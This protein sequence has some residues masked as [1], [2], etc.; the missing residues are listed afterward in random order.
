MG[1]GE[2]GADL[3]A[4]PAV[5]EI[6]RS[7]RIELVTSS[8]E[9]SPRTSRPL[10]FP[11]GATTDLPRAV[12]KSLLWGPSA[13]VG[14]PYNVA[15]LSLGYSSAHTSERQDSAALTY[16]RARQ[17]RSGSRPIHFLGCGPRLPR[18][19]ADLGR[20]VTA[21]KTPLRPLSLGTPETVPVSIALLTR[22]S[23]ESVASTW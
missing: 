11:S 23:S 21:L 5:F 20:P 14:T 12:G 1:I 17:E 3:T 10:R 19:A 15:G 22:F 13:S 2:R 7:S 9:R 18:S 6:P 16:L 4:A 8:V